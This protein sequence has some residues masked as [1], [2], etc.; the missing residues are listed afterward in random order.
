MELT[1]FSQQVLARVL[2]YTQNHQF[3]VTRHFVKL[4]S[5]K[6]FVL[7]VPMVVFRLSI[8]FIL[9]FFRFDLSAFIFKYANF[10]NN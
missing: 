7:M 5:L 10:F 1:I 8:F 6:Y 3:M 2:K 4:F 9:D